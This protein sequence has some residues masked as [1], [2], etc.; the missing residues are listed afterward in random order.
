M[1]EALAYVAG[2]FDGEGSVTFA[3]KSTTPVVHLKM[4]QKYR[5]V[6]D[7]IQGLLDCGAIYPRKNDG[8]DYVISDRNSVLR[9]IDLIEP[10]SR[11]KQQQ[12]RIA[13]ELALMTG[14]PGRATRGVGLDQR[15]ALV[16]QVDLLKV[17]G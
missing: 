12:L 10:Y 9:V 13:R 1:S 6:L 16:A 4:S 11:V 15:L 5:A 17:T 7:E 3:H 8:F 14:I 2:F